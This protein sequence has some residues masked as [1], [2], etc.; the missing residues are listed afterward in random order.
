MKEGEE[1]IKN[2]RKA[3]RTKRTRKTDQEKDSTRG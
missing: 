2:N 1:A 3:E